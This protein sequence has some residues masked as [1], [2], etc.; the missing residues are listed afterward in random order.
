[1]TGGKPPRR[2]GH[3]FE[4]E[5][6]SKARARGLDAQRAYASNG[7]AL[8]EHETVDCLIAGR[9]CQCKRRKTLASYICPTDYQDAV[10]LRA[11]RSESLIVIRFVD[12]LELLKFGGD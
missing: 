2:K 7:Q 5:C 8:G 10:I 6:V 3:A 9:R 1:M 4:R 12:F 11:D